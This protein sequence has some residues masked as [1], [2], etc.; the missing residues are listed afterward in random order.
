MTCK[1]CDGSGVVT[2]VRDN[3]NSSHAFSCICEKGAERRNI[4][5]TPWNGQETQVIR[6]EVYRY[7]F[8]G[9]MNK[10]PIRAGGF[11]EKSQPVE[12]EPVKAEE[13]IPF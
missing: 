11:I 3:F 7:K 6:N 8:W 1:Y 10:P 5:I 4:L 13:Q 9:I 12:V 2:L